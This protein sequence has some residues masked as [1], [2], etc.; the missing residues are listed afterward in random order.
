[1]RVLAAQAPP[2]DPGKNEV[3]RRLTKVQI[4]G[5]VV[6]VARSFQL[7]TSNSM[8]AASANT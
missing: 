7:C 5:D 3:Y 4:G 8:D 1:M 2:I 6:C